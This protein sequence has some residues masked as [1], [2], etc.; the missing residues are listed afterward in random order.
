M[1]TWVFLFT[2]EYNIT[3]SSNQISPKRILRWSMQTTNNIHISVWYHEYFS[4]N[5]SNQ[6]LS[7]MAMRL[8]TLVSSPSKSLKLKKNININIKYIYLIQKTVKKINLAYSLT[9]YNFQKPRC[10]W[11]SH[12][13][14]CNTEDKFRMKHHPSTVSGPKEYQNRKMSNKEFDTAWWK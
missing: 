8:A 12:C 5:C 13:I 3:S 1:T 14:T 7:I 2:T 10:V 4:K 6:L 11:N 9:R